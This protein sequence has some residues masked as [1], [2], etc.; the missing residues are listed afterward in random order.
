VRWI[1]H[2]YDWVLGW[3]ESR[4]GAVALFFF[5][6]AESV[7]FP[8]PPDVLLLALA[9]GCRTRAWR[10]AL[11]CS[12]GSVVGGAA[13]YALGYAAWMGSAGFTPLAAF[14]FDH[15]PGVSEE[16]Y[17]GVRERFAQW[18]FWIVFSAGFTPIPYKIFTIAA[19]A[20]NIPFFL[21]LVAS[22]VSRSARFFLIA[23]LIHRFGAPI[24]RFLDRYFNWL[25]F[26]FVLL[27]LGGF[28]VARAWL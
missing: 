10:F 15:V 23:A 4:Y 25:T 8:V 22:A 6:V 2:L 18:G 5:A 12:V 9:L 21:F 16:V 26:L 17:F 14:F 20:F 13:G 28:V 11:I 1:R 19:G 3:A 7:F 27:L 24:S